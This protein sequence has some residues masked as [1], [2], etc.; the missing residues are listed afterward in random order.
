MEEDK[1]RSKTICRGRNK[2]EDL[3]LWEKWIVASP[4]PLTYTQK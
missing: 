1:K 2:K 4:L 3:L